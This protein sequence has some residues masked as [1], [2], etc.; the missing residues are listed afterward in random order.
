MNELS[1]S[2]QERARKIETIILNAIQGNGK[3]VALAAAIGF[4]ESTISKMK[5]EVLAHFAQL[6]AHAGL[7]VV[8]VDKVCVSREMYEAMTLINQRAMADP[9]IA[10]KL[11]WEEE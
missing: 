11:V 6:L 9:E 1:I 7:K 3:Q 10:R 2:P 4:H 5:G 8:A